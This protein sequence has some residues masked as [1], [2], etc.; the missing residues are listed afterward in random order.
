MRWQDLGDWQE[1]IL[2]T[3]FWFFAAAAALLV[4]VGVLDAAGVL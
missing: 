4:L 1:R 3:A 2:K